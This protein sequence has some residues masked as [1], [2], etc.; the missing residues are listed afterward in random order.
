M[1]IATILTSSCISRTYHG[2]TLIILGEIVDAMTLLMVEFDK[3]NWVYSFW[4]YQVKV[5]ELTFVKAFL[6]CHMMH[7]SG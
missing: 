2:P 4:V 1:N 5:S 3:K 6:N 7:I